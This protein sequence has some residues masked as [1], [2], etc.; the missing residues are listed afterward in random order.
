MVVSAQ[1]YTEQGPITDRYTK[2]IGQ[3]GDDKLDIRLGGIYALERLAVDSQRDHSTV[4]EVLSAFVRERSRQ[5]GA[6]KPPIACLRSKD[7]SPFPCPTTDVQAALT[8]LGRLPERDGISRGDLS[9][10]YLVGADLSEANLAEANLRGADLTE[11]RAAAASAH[12]QV[13]DPRAARRA[14]ASRRTRR[15]SRSCQ[16]AM[17]TRKPSRRHEPTT[18][19]CAITTMT[20]VV[21]IYPPVV[22]AVC[23]LSSVL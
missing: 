21:T 4:V 7:D 9:C 13:L 22:L 12:V 11:A 2:A 15:A 3:V 1:S 14:R 8:V 17:P 19:A 5:G 18:T 16:Q 10:A 20:H 6:E 23:A